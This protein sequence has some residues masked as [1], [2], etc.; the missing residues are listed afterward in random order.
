M[1]NKAASNVIPMREFDRTSDPQAAQFERLLKECQKLAQDRLSQSVAAMLDK[2]EEALWA[3]ADQTMDREKRDVYMTAK[4][5]AL[6][7]R[8][9]I[10]DQFRQ[11]YLAEFE[12]RVQREA[13]RDEFSQYDLSSLELG[14]VNDEDL[15]ETLKVNDMAA[16]LRRYCEEELNA[17]DQR[18]GVLIGDANLQADGNPFSPQAVCTAYKLTCR[19]LDSNMK[20]RMIFHKLFDDHVLDDVRSIYKDLN[21][22]LIQRSILPKIRFGVRRGAGAIGRRPGAAGAAALPILPAAMQA[23]VAPPCRWASIR[24]RRWECQSGW[25]PQMLGDAGYAGG[26]VGA[27]SRTFFRHPIVCSHARVHPAMA[28]AVLGAPGGAMGGGIPGGVVGGIP[29]GMVG[30]AAGGVAGA[31]PAGGMVQ[32]PGFPPILGAS[33]RGWRRSISWN[34]RRWRRT[35]CCPVQALASL[36]AQALCHS[37]SC[38]ARN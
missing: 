20:I 5:K 6:G 26:E 12:R 37:A 13:K 15:E 10:E 31:V 18:I 38:R 7:Q 34:G 32:I 1:S 33:S 25:C 4:D 29:G 17:L 30:G 3:L 28:G 35:R 11:N 27:A 2:A 8:K 19:T 23:R 36:R 24:W 21:A 22:L 16:K 9:T 14:L